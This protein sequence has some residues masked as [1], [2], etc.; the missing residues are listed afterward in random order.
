MYFSYSLNLCSPG[1]VMLHFAYELNG[2]CLILA[3]FLW[4]CDELEDKHHTP[5]SI[6]VLQLVSL[7]LSRSLP[8][9]F[10][11]RLCFHSLSLPVIHS[12][13]FFLLFSTVALFLSRCRLP[14]LP[15]CLCHPSRLF[16]PPARG[17]LL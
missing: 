10:S 14:V 6:I 12:Y 8:F 16:S 15:A 4:C 7:S 2:R 1:S 13:S 3:C 17:H 9:S 5:H 11:L